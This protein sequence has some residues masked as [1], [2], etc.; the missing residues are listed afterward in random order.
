M[1]NDDLIDR[2]PESRRLVERALVWL[3]D[4]LRETDVD[5]VILGGLVP[6]YLTR[7]QVPPVP[8][9]LGT[10]DVDLLL[11]AHVDGADRPA[12]G[13]VENALRT[14]GFRNVESGWRWQIAIEGRIVKMEFLCDLADQPAEVVIKPAACEE[15][16]AMNLRGTRFVGRD[17]SEEAVAGRLPDGTE[18]KLVVKVAALGGYL[19]AKGFALR[20]RA[21]PKDY[22]DFTYV[23][24]NN[25]EGGPAEAAR[26]LKAGELRD[27]LPTLRS[28]FAEVQERY[29]TQNDDGPR[30]YASESLKVEPGADDRRLRADAVAAV[31]MF[32]D[33]LGVLA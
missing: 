14:L 3:L 32:I 18:T 15:L 28:T 16:G 2:S 24:I 5:L 23:L 19:L 12:F 13:E 1:A 22:Y 33:E 26:H 21:A 4:A 11:L 9:H 7:G 6:E 8:A 30:H 27:E 10:T 31:R 29:R 17:F 20:T 25:R